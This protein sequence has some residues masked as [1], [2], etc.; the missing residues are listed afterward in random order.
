MSIVGGKI[1]H[2]RTAK[3]YPLHGRRSQNGREQEERRKK[4]VVGPTSRKGKMVFSH[5]N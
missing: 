1:L 4:E 3:T 5:G 2:L